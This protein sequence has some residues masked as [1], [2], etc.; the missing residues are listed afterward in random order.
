M[1]VVRF[2]LY[3]VASSRF[4]VVR[5][6]FRGMSA[7]GTIHYIRVCF[8]CVKLDCCSRGGIYS[9]PV[10]APMVA[11]AREHEIIPH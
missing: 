8:S 1:F 11:P 2:L 7:F 4:H 6:R 3:N 10:L 5:N 9:T